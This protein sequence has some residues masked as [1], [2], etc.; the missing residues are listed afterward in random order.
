MFR[1][2]NF[3]IINLLSDVLSAMLLKFLWDSHNALLFLGCWDFKEVPDLAEISAQA[4]LESGSLTTII[5][6][7][8]LLFIYLSSIIV[9][10]SSSSIYS[11]IH[12]TIYP[13]IYLYIQYPSIYPISLLCCN[14]IWIGA[15]NLWSESRMQETIV[16]DG[17]CAPKYMMLCDMCQLYVILPL[18]LP[19]LSKES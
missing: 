8:S 17:W 12:V 10:L 16:M 11:P 13:C 15:C 3:I 18:K 2:V 5:L 7:L 1:P 14:H 6:Y 19:V 9:Y 4:E